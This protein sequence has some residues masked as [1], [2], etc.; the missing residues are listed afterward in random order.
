MERT[1]PFAVESSL[2]ICYDSTMSSPPPSQQPIRLMEYPCTICCLKPDFRLNWD[3]PRRTN[4]S[5]HAIV[6]PATEPRASERVF[7]NAKGRVLGN[8]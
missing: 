2:G 7:L 6:S 5:Y 1:H 4:H 3:G 8:R